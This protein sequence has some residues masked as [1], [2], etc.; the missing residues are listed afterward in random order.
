MPFSQYVVIDAMY[1]GDAMRLIIYVYFP[2][3]IIR[4]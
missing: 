2:V 4:G 3:Y 1:G